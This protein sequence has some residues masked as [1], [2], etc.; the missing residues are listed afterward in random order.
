MRTARFCGSEEV[1]DP[2]GGRHHP[3]VKTN[4]RKNITFPQ[5]RLRVVIKLRSSETYLFLEFVVSAPEILQAVLWGGRRVAV[6]VRGTRRW[7][8]YTWRLFQLV[9]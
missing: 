5:L 2:G 9:F 7:V 6:F 3:P 1:S 8:R 4:T